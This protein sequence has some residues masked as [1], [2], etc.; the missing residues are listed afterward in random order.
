MIK[1][2]SKLCPK[3]N[4]EM[5]EGTYAGSH[6]YWTPQ[7]MQGFLQQPG[8]RVLSFACEQCGFIENYI[9]RFSD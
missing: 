3:C 4:E 7:E 5:K 8:K 6:S 1:P 2:N 9:D